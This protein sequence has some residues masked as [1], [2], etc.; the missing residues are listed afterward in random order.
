MTCT[1]DGRAPTQMV[2]PAASPE[3][4]EFAVYSPVILNYKLF[5]FYTL[6]LYNKIA[7]FIISSKCY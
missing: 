2:N 6:D 5:Y 7:S 1:H 3:H 4:S